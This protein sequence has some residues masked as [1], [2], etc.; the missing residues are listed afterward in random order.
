M[1][2]HLQ[3]TTGLYGLEAAHYTD[4]TK[5]SLLFITNQDCLH[6]DRKNFNMFSP[7]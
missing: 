2:E 7:I 3:D 6:G 5:Q 4:T 1:Y